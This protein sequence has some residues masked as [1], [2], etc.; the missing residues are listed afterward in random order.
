MQQSSA[1]SLL[2]TATIP[3]DFGGYALIEVYAIDDSGTLYRGF[4]LI[5]VKPNQRFSSLTAYPVSLAFNYPA[6][7][8]TIN[9]QGTYADGTL[10]T[11]TPAPGT[12]FTSSNPAAATVDAQGVVTAVANGSASIVAVV[13]GATVSVP[14]SVAVS[15]AP[16]QFAPVPAFTMNAGTSMTVMLQATSP[17]N[18]QITVSAPSLPSFAQFSAATAG[19]ATLTPARSLRCGSLCYRHRGSGQRHSAAA[20]HH[21]GELHGH[22]IG[23]GR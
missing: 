3:S 22:G 10:V 15:N 1:G 8:E 5:L 12:A 7:T 4:S 18:N 16:P 19:A 6:Q 11:I 13:N 21:D 20:G 23:A 14:V 9:L 17:F 2:G